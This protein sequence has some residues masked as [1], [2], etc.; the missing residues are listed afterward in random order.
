[1]KRKQNNMIYDFTE[2]KYIELCPHCFKET[3]IIN[4]FIPQI[5]LH[6]K[7]VIKPCSL[8]NHNFVNCNKCSIIIR[9]KRGD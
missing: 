7:S 3:E 2:S 9:K 6:C 8:C 4:L 5:C 1:M